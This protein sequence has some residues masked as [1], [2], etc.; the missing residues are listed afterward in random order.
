[1]KQAILEKINATKKTWNQKIIPSKRRSLPKK[2]I[3]GNGYFRFSQ[4][5]L[6]LRY[7]R[8]RTLSDAKGRCQSA[9]SSSWHQRCQSWNYDNDSWSTQ[10]YHQIAWKKYKLS[11]YKVCGQSANLL[12]GQLSLLGRSI[13]YIFTSNHPNWK[14]NILLTV[15]DFFSWNLSNSTRMVLQLLSKNKNIPKF[16]QISP[17][18][19][20]ITIVLPEIDND[21]WNL[22]QGQY[23][24]PL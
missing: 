18:Q 23:H 1:M 4:P 12:E 5:S 3:F 9:S 7:S 2:S 22:C 6:S 15:K 16:V 17:K 14:W 20:T 10:W 13:P 21:F 24:W 11:D 8:A 19:S